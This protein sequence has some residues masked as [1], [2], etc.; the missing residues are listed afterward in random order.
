MSTTK[1]TTDQK[2]GS[3]TA[4][5]CDA[6]LHLVAQGDEDALMAL[7]YATRRMIFSVSYST[8]RDVHLSE[9]AVQDTMLRIWS[10]AASYRGKEQAKSWICSIARHLSMDTLRRRGR[11]ISLETFD[12]G[13]IPDA[14][15]TDQDTDG[16]LDLMTGLSRLGREEAL[17]FSLRNIAG[18]SHLE[19]AHLMEIP[20]HTVRY[21]YRTAINKLKTCLSGPDAGIDGSRRDD[22]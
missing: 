22:R 1:A 2:L 8:L 6:L 11:E 18:L 16:R 19:I 7:Y 17:A 13:P 14:L 10:N 3:K 12:D 5:E 21:R 4:A 9:D 15:T 20:Y